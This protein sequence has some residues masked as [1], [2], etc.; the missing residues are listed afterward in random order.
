MAADVTP[1]GKAARVKIGAAGRRPGDAPLRDA[2]TL[3]RQADI[4]LCQVVSDIAQARGW[5]PE[6]PYEATPA[7]AEWHDLIRKVNDAYDA[8]YAAA[9]RTQVEASDDRT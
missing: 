8:V 7:E 4:A 9:I 5:A 2:L 1:S 3:L 6:D